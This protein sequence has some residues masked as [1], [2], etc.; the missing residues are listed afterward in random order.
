MKRAG[1]LFTQLNIDISLNS[2]VSGEKLV[3]NPSRTPGFLI[4]YKNILSIL[5]GEKHKYC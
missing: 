4:C 5:S 3:I 1:T 2:Y